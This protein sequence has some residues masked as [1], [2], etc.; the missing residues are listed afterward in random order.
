MNTSSSIASEDVD[1]V[2][3][4][5]AT[6]WLVD[7]AGRTIYYP[8]G[9]ASGGY[10]VADAACENAI[11]EA[12]RRYS[13]SYKRLK[14]LVPLLVLPVL[15]PF[16]FLIRSYPI[17]AFAYLPAVITLA[18]LAERL[19]RRSR[20]AALFAGMDEVPAADPGAVKARYVAGCG[21]LVLICVMSLVLH[22]YGQRVAA[23]AADRN[24]IDFYRDISRSLA[25]ASLFALMLWGMIA[26]REKVAARSGASRVVLGVVLLGIL[27]FAGQVA[28]DFGNPRPVVTISEDSFYCT[29]RV[30]WTDIADMSLRSGRRWQE[31]AH[32]E[33]VP[34]RSPFLNGK[35]AED[36][37]ID[38]LNSDYTEVYGVIYREWQAARSS[39]AVGS[40]KRLARAAGR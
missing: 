22:L 38:G 1:S 25:F 36:C 10:V 33:F 8:Y 11:R 35:P 18:G 23:V 30:A 21:I 24:T 16:Y 15:S 29:W 3:R 9:K 19:I 2:A 13:A 26:A 31:Y 4:S 39:A 7:G 6:R 14:P 37:E 34:G 17:L 20:M 27:F 40:G 12:D 32:V 5:D 28:I